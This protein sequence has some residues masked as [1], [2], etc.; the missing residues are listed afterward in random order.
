MIIELADIDANY[1]TNFFYGYLGIATA[2]VFASTFPI[3][4][5]FRYRVGLRHCE[6]RRRH[7]GHGRAQT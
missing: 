6:E 1:N 4:T 3:L 5:V 7:L 2:L